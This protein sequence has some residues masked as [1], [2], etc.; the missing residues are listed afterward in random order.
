MLSY[1]ISVTTSRNYRCIT[2]ALYFIQSYFMRNSF[3]VF[4]LLSCFQP[5][6]Q[7]QVCLIRNLPCLTVQN[8]WSSLI[9]HSFIIKQSVDFSLSVSR[10]LLWH[11][12]TLLF[13]YIFASS[14]WIDFWLSFVS[15]KFTI[16]SHC[17]DRKIFSLLANNKNPC[18]VSRSLKLIII[19]RRILYFLLLIS[20]TYE[21]FQL[22]YYFYKIPSQWTT[23][24]TTLQFWHTM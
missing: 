18:S 11:R 9:S 23:N 13:S 7:I 6:S 4:L 1:Y 19:G 10:N 5:L 3:M 22:Q 17:W 20:M 8:L 2:H 14:L 24:F 15:R 16:N 12:K 21:I